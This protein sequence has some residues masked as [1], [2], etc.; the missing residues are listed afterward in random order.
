MCGALNNLRSD[1]SDPHFGS[2]AEE[3]VGPDF[4]E[5][6]DLHGM[7]HVMR[8]SPHV[9]HTL[10][11]SVTSVNVPPSCSILNE[12]KEPYYADDPNLKVLLDWGIKKDIEYGTYR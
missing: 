2:E 5:D 9:P 1:P 3:S 11:T 7:A 8:E 10:L 6:Q 4:Y 12:D